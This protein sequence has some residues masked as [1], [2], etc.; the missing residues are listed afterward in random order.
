[1]A[2]REE[3]VHIE[4]PDGSRGIALADIEAVVDSDGNIV[5][6]INCF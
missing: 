1:M 6:A 4:R 5:G 2:V 3:E